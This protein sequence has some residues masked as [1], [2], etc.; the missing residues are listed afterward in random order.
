MAADEFSVQMIEDI[1]D[2]ETALVGGHFG[3]EEDLQQQVAEF[4]GQVREVAPFDGVEYFVGLFKRVLADRVEC[5]FAV[6]GA[7]VRSAEALH[8][9][10]GLLKEGGRLRGVGA[11]S[12]GG[13]FWTVWKNLVHRNQCSAANR[14][15]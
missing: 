14:E 10:N 9:G 8:D 4:F 13:L 7:T 12:G 11:G 3:V 5:L 6:P 1:R 2:G 15:R